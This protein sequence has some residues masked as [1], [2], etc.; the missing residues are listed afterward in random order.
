[1]P[2]FALQPDAVILSL[3]VAAKALG[4]K[5]ECNRKELVDRKE[6]VKENVRRAAVE[7]GSTVLVLWVQVVS[8]MAQ[9]FHQIFSFPPEKKSI[10]VVILTSVNFPLKC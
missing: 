3:L 1:M 9:Q 2:N 8:G 6:I 4:D 10:T 5:I 7:L